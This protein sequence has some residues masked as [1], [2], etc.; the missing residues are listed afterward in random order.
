MGEFYEL[1]VFKKSGTMS[2]YNTQS[3]DLLFEH[4]L[5]VASRVIAIQNLMESLSV[6]DFKQGAYW[7]P[8]HGY[9]P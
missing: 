5:D 2:I 4:D 8:Q 3:G 6:S 7:V 9:H 1:V